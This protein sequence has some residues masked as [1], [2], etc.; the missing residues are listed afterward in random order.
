MLETVKT[1]NYNIAI[2]IRLSKEDVDRGYDESESI[3][4]QRDLLTE[5]AKKF[6]GGYNL[7]EIYIDQGF[8]GTNF[9]R[10][11]FQRM[12][13]DIELGKINMVITKDLSRLGRDY[14]ETGEY[15]EKWFPE[16]N[17]RY[18]SVTDGIDTFVPNNGNNDIAP[19]KSILNDM[20]SKDLSKKIR[21]ALHTMQKQGKW[22]G[23][24]TA[25]GYMRDQN[26]KNK[27]IICEPEADIVKTIFNMAYS[28]N[29][30]SVIRDY[31]NTNNIPTANQIRYNKMAFWENKT[32]KNILKNEVY[33]G[34]TI[35]NK[36]SRI[37]YKNRKLKSN[38]QE[39]WNIVENTH[40]P[41]IDRQVFDKVQKMIIVQKYNRNEKKHKFLLDGLL[42]CYEC[43]HKIG[44]RARKNGRLDMVCNN[45]RRNSKL[46]LC[47]SHGFSYEKL[48]NY[49]LEYIKQVFQNIDNKKIELAVK[50]N[51]TKYDYSKLM[52]KLEIEI[53]L[54]N[55]NIDKM[56]L[57]KLNGKVSE[58]MYERVFKRLIDEKKQKEIEYIKLKEMSEYNKENNSQEIEKVVKEF[59]SL[60]KPTSEIMK[61]II[62]RIEIHQDKQVDI[63][64]NFK[65]LDVLKNYK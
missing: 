5:Y 23:G 41:I 60:K 13:R 55:E 63:L 49:I 40:E 35:Q 47:T 17:I 24:K 43:K 45:Y 57:D 27:L 15:I 21:T 58:E 19:F 33:I 1:E 22:V 8:T 65:K 32:I 42:F 51:I 14:I 31:L 59:L 38:P 37:S 2:Y 3:K 29:N 4:N 12:I 30:I 50:K 36:R 56:Y 62:N 10:P 39:Q 61:V 16:N 25:I 34:N 6:G 48:E 9:N 44:V 64:F 53:K 20:Y 7:V 11:A 54:I 52:Q 26:D 28:G 18:V 46:G